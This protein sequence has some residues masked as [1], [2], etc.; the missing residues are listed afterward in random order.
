MEG[1]VSRYGIQVALS[2][3]KKGKVSRIYVIW[4]FNLSLVSQFIKALIFPLGFLW[5][6][7]YHQ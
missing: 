1:G 4:M 7:L 6:S 2:K 5:P 3:M